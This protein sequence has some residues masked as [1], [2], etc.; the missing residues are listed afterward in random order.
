MALAR[1]G[2]E[3]T[4]F[5]ES[6]PMPARGFSPRRGWLARLVRASPGPSTPNQAQAR[7]SSDGLAAFGSEKG[8]AAQKPVSSPPAP[9]LGRAPRTGRRRAVWSLL[10]AAST[11]L[12]AGA[13][14]VFQVVPVRPKPVQALEARPGRVTFDTQPEGAEVRINQELRGLT[15]LTLSLKPGHHAV[16]I[17]R[18]PQERI[19]PLELAEGAEVTQ[20]FEFPADASTLSV[21]T[22]P[23]GARVVIDREVRGVSPVTVGDLTPASHTVTVTGTSGSMERM[24]TTE[25]GTTMSVV[26]SL[27]KA[28]SI[29][30]GWLTVAAPFTVTLLERTEIV[31]TSLSAKIMIPAGRH[32]LDLVNESLGYQDHRRVE[33]ASGKTAEIHVDARAPLSVNARPWAE[34]VID[35]TSAGQTPIANFLVSLGTHQVV[36]RH[37]ELGERRQSVVV[38][39]QG[40]NRVAV[41]MSR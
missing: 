14:V 40:P 19:V 32:E 6:N 20:Y 4:S 2:I 34:V 5:M 21:T 36:F 16:T 41:D 24:V 30:A 17:R 13:L 26:F 31:G 29:D 1:S 25:A 23:P 8:P 22:D 12:A 11:V 18:G 7:D 39:A 38:T 37:P 33:I 15:P 9:E 3:M 10:V 35:G 27:P 28:S